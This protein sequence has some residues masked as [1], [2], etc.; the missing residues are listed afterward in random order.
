[1]VAV[2]I[3]TAQPAGLTPG[4]ATVTHRE[5]WRATGLRA[6]MVRKG[7]SRTPPAG[8]C[9]RGEYGPESSA[10]RRCLSAKGPLLV[11]GLHVREGLEPCRRPVVAHSHVQ[12]EF[13]V[14]IL[15]PV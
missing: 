3:R 8:R 6:G 13:L 7:R 15:D 11:S 9:P 14:R 12:A 5:A 1:M 10:G 4:S 2:R